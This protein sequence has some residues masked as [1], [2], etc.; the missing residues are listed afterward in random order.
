MGIDLPRAVFVGVFEFAGI[1]AEYLLALF[2]GEDDLGGLEDL[3]V[4]RLRVAL[5]AV[6]PEFAALGADL[7]LSIQNVF[8]HLFL[9][10]NLIYYYI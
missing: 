5:G 2:A 10:S 4:L 8:A 7:H 3:V 6:E 1:L 9:N